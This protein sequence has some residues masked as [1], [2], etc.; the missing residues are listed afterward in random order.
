M[1]EIHFYASGPSKENPAK[2]WTTGTPKEKRLILDLIQ[3]ALRWSDSTGI[4]LWVGAWMPGDYNKGDHYTIQEQIKF[5]TFMTCSLKSAK[6]PF[7]VNADIQFFDF[8]QKRW[9]EDRLPVLMAILNPR[10]EK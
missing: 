6:I 1:A 3:T 5:A 9:R 7:A 2:L 4:R 10:C 8:K